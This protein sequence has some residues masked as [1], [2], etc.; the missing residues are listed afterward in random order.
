MG[1]I[2]ETCEQLA[3]KGCPLQLGDEVIASILEVRG[4][5]SQG[6]T[7]EE[8]RAKVIDGLKLMLSPE[9]GEAGDQR[10]REPLRFTIAA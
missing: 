8:A 1:V 5:Y 6:R 4:V 2:E 3:V 10:E 7:R 9:P